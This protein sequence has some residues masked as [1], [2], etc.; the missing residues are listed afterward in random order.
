MPKGLAS[1][2]GKER[3]CRDDLVGEWRAGWSSGAWRVPLHRSRSAARVSARNG[4]NAL[5]RGAER[6]STKA[7]RQR[8]RRAFG[9]ISGGVPQRSHG[10]EEQRGRRQS[11]TAEP[12]GGA[13]APGSAHE[14]PGGAPVVDRLPRFGASSTPLHRCGGYGQ[15]LAASCNAGGLDQGHAVCY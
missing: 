2:A 10:G 13:Q 1:G 6:G 9:P 14:T 4:P 7:R 5:F 3:R 8:V 15:S 11:V 12:G